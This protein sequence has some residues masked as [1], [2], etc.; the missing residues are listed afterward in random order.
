MKNLHR[1]QPVALAGTLLILVC[2]IAFSLF[3]LEKEIDE[4]GL[5]T[6]DER[7]WNSTRVEMELLRLI[8]Q[9]NFFVITETDESRAAIDIRKEILWS[10][11]NIITQGSTKEL[12]EQIDQS[13]LETAYRLIGLLEKLDRDIASLTPNKAKHYSAQFEDFV[14]LYMQASRTVASAISEVESTF[15]IKV[16]HNYR[17]MAMLLL[18][19]LMIGSLFTWVNYRELRRNQRLARE[20]AAAN[21][22]KSEFLS[23]MSHEIRTPLNGIIGS[24]QLM[25]LEQLPPT[26]TPLIQDMN[27]CSQN[28]LQL[29]NSILDLSRLQQ[30]K[31]QLEYQ[32]FSLHQAVEDV[33]RVVNGSIQSKKL[34]LNIRKDPALPSIIMGDHF[35]LQQ[36]LINLLSNA[37]KFT[38][39]GHVTLRLL[40]NRQLDEQ[41]YE[42]KIEVSDT[43]I[44][45]SPEAQQQIFSPFTQA[46]SSTTRRFGGSGLGLSLCKEIISSMGGEIGV[47]S[48]I[49]QGSTFW[50]LLNVEVAD[51]TA[52]ITNMESAIPDVQATALVSASNHHQAKNSDSD[53]PALILVV[54][55]NVINANLAGAILKKL[56]YQCEFAE[57]G[58]IAFEMCQ[59][60]QYQLI[61]MDCQMPVMDGLA[62]TFKLRAESNLNQSTPIVA[63]TANAMLE[64]QQRCIEV[65]MNAFIAK[66]VSIQR[67]QGVLEQYIA[68]LK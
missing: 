39:E 3:K 52:V 48:Q 53:R 17:L 66:P 64:D 10:R 49:G 51:S 40:L 32:A 13:S 43:G 57:N 22:A 18:L 67:L 59:Q 23:N 65:G 12:I 45:I 1:Y 68:E 38:S 33:V 26:L 7:Y 47:R 9:L 37:A 20:A 34:Q 15:A 58:Q 56:G 14:A 24:L 61:L 62:C 36:V 42:I 27:A 25:R 31:L 55:D 30:Q 46:D 54:E 63:L 28:L 16:Q 4:F 60:Q 44:G 19:V 2:V 29:L 8:N 41:H 50:I 6:K 35:R 5:F 11:V 21:Q